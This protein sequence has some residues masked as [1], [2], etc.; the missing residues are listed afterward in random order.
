MEGGTMCEQSLDDQMPERR[1]WACGWEWRLCNPHVKDKDEDQA[2][3]PPGATF[4]IKDGNCQRWKALSGK[5]GEKPSG[6]EVSADEC[7]SCRFIG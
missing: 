1:H 6:D 5:R 7:W 4:A 3:S 2:T